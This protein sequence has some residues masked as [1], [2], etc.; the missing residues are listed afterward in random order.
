VRR[1]RTPLEARGGDGGGEPEDRERGQDRRRRGG[2]RDGPRRD[3]ARAEQ[4]GGEGDRVP[5]LPEADRGGRDVGREHRGDP[6]VAGG[7]DERGGGDRAEEPQPAHALGAP[8]E[9]E[10]RRAGAHRER[11]GER[12]GRRDDLVDRAGHDDRGEEPGA[13]ARRGGQRDV[14]HA[15]PLPQP[16]PGGDQRERG[17]PRH[18]HP[19]LLA[20]PAP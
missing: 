6:G 2:A 4:E 9:G 12:D 17:G 5:A 10:H 1:P 16:D 15:A 13:S 20:D 18:Q 19:D 11:G 7:A 8:A 3:L 14:R